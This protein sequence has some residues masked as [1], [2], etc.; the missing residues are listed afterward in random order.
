MKAP[1]EEKNKTRNSLLENSVYHF[2]K[3]LALTVSS[4]ALIY[5]EKNMKSVMLN[6]KENIY[7]PSKRDAHPFSLDL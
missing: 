6:H 7:V 5:F 4:S 3:N 2:A 1:E